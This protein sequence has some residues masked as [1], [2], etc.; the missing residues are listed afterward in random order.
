MPAIPYVSYHA[1]IHTYTLLAFNPNKFFQLLYPILT[2]KE[3]MLLL[4]AYVRDKL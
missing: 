1:R 2:H 4:R 3:T